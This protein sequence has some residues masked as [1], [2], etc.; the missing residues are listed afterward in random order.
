MIKNKTEDAF[1]KFALILFKSKK[2]KTI[3]LRLLNS[4]TAMD[5]SDQNIRKEIHDLIGVYTRLRRPSDR[6]YRDLE[7]ALVNHY[8]GLRRNKVE[9]LE[10]RNEERDECWASIEEND[11]CT[12]E[13]EESEDKS[14]L[15]NAKDVVTQCRENLHSL[16]HDIKLR[17]T[18]TEDL[19]N[20]IKYNK[21]AT[22]KLK[23]IQEV[24]D[25]QMAYLSD[26]V[27]TVA[28]LVS[29]MKPNQANEELIK[30]KKVLEGLIAEQTKKIEEMR[31]KDDEKVRS[32]HDE[33]GMLNESKVEQKKE[34][35]QL[36]QEIKELSLTYG[37]QYEEILVLKEKNEHLMDENCELIDASKENISRIK[38]LERKLKTKLETLKERE[39]VINR[40]NAEIEKQDRNIKQYQRE[41]NDLQKQIPLRLPQINKR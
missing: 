30:E 6:S 1:E 27:D 33:I 21:E 35:K 38:T 4:V 19:L 3:A 10:I 37:T 41:I 2:Y 25:K 24:H 23:E 11:I 22:A 28:N 20:E 16:H 14:T 9:D 34:L 8:K 7:Q 36:E 40:L 5:V 13:T 32:L 18:Y 39:T 26:K 12:E 17:K 15:I 29:N 31:Q